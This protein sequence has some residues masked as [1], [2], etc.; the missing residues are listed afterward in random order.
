M[1]ILLSPTAYLST[2]VS[3]VRKTELAN[4]QTL[5]NHLPAPLK[6]FEQALELEDLKTASGFL[7]ILQGL[8]ENVEEEPDEAES[9]S[10]KQEFNL[11]A[12]VVRLMKVAH[13]KGDYELCSE[14]ARFMMG[15]D[16]RGRA[17]RRV[18]AA[19]GFKEKLTHLEA[20]DGAGL[21]LRRPNSGVKGKKALSKPPD[22]SADESAP[23]ASPRSGSAGETEESSHWW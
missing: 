14:L 3:C 2:I 19:V 8:E 16:P 10:S 4:W 1:Q 17:L 7:I 13:E 20:V 21:A 11:E 5:F 12:Q 6:L 23:N 18:I 9:G 15:V 22:E